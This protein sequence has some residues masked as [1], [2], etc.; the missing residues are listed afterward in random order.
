MIKRLKLLAV[1]IV[2]VMVVSGFAVVASAINS[3]IISA[4]NSNQPPVNQ[5]LTPDKAEPQTAG[6][7]ITWTASATDPDG[8]TLSYQ[9]W[10]KGPATGG[11][12]TIMQSWS[13]GNTWTW[14]TSTADIGDTDISVWIRDGHHEPPDKYDLEKVYSGYTIQSAGNQ[15]PVNP[16]L[17]PD[18]AEPQT[19]GTAITW[20]ASAT[21]PDD[22]D[23]LSYRF[24]IK[25]PS[26]GGSWSIK[27]D[28]STDNNWTWSTSSTDIGNT[29]ISVWIRDGHHKPPDKYDLEKVYSGYTIQSAGNQPPVNP[30]LTPDKAE[31]QTAGTSITWTAS[32]TDPDDDTLSYQFWIRGPST[33]GSWTIM[34][35]WSTGNTWTW[36][37][38]SA[39]I[40][41]TDISVWI[42]DGHHEPT[43]KYDLEKVYSGY[44]IQS[45][46]NQPPVNPTL[47]PDKAEPQTAGTS[48]TWTA[49]ATDPDDDTLSY[50]FWI[51]GP[52]TGN[53]WTI[54]QSWG[55]DNTWTW[56][57]SSADIGDT[58]ISVWIRDGHHEPPDKYDLEK[59]YS[60]YTIQ[61]AGNQPPV[62][63][64]L[65]PDKAEPQTAGTSI[66]WTASATDPDGDT[67]SYQFWIKGPATGNSWTIMQSWS[68]DNTWTWSTSSA[69]IGDTDISVWIR[70]GHHEPPDK[71]DLEKVYSCYTIQSAGNQPP[72]NPT[73][74]PDKAEPQTAGT[75]I[76]WTASATDPDDDT[77]SYQ[78]WIKGPATGGSWTIMQSWSTGNTWTW[79]TDTGWAS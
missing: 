42:R 70:D 71:Y 24:W 30:T 69:D 51:K 59:V 37:T 28:W 12:W 11:S 6:T 7:S 2:I 72:V 10:I 64:T 67:L 46:G 8:D 32:A 14:H 49:S 55:T 39:D 29:D 17:T 63:P 54:M 58:D 62:N 57:T 66:T 22:G 60:C 79:S 9:F 36:S 76:T 47:T 21:D 61:S 78:F 41:D 73:L 77:L 20:T 65:T 40:G 75:S 5:T 1:F 44:T 3:T 27:R 38:S 56:S 50:Q 15:P 35:S 68:T 23:T 31:P 53:S 74:T 43:E 33:G 13:T 34:Q 4:A 25:G 45:A 18:K 52:A 26:T 19:A 48:I 16:T